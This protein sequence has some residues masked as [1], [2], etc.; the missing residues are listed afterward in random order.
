M[1]AFSRHPDCHPGSTLVDARRSTAADGRCRHAAL[2]DRERSS[3]EPLGG[4]GVLTGQARRRSDRPVSG[5][6]EAACGCKPG[7]TSHLR[8]AD[9][10]SATVRATAAVANRMPAGSRQVLPVRGLLHFGFSSSFGASGAG[11]DFGNSFASSTFAAGSGAGSTVGGVTPSRA[12]ASAWRR[13]SCTGKGNLRSVASGFFTSLLVALQP[14]ARAVE[15]GSGLR[16]LAQLPVGHRRDESSVA[17]GRLLM[18]SIEPRKSPVRYSAQP[19]DCRHRPSPGF[20]STARRANWRARSASRRWLGGR[21]QEVDD[22]KLVWIIRDCW[23]ASL[24]TALINRTRGQS[25]SRRCGSGNP[26]RCAFRI[27][28]QDL[29]SA[30]GGQTW[31]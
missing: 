27:R 8:A 28:D 21:G 23:T 17:V 12:A 2:P 25:N 10:G 1:P 6:A 16:L 19:N 9:L 26:G 14:L 13:F 29:A 30:L 24:M 18:A 20:S 5:L 3:R 4:I 15:V 31:Q 22:M 7:V 11:V